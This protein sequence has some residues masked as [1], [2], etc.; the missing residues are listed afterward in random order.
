MTDI[1]D[2]FQKELGPGGLEARGYTRAVDA[3]DT[4]DILTI[5]GVG[6]PYG[7]VARIEGWFEEWDELVAPGAWRSAISR[8]DVDIV[9]SYNHNLDFLI[10]RT[11]DTLTLTDPDEEGLLYQAIVNPDDP[12]AVGIHARVARRD[13]TGSS[14]WFRVEKDMWEEPSEDNDLEVPLRTILRADLYEVGPVVFPAFPTTTAEASAA[15][16]R[17][18]GYKRSALAAMDGSLTAAGVTRRASQ[19]AY[20]F[21]FL[22]DPEPEIRALFLQDPDLR[23]KVC[24]LDTAATAASLAQPHVSIA[25]SEVLFA[26]AAGK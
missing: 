19:A 14:V 5:S 11:P 15:G 2:R 10:A 25:N 23:D 8:P 12:N 17:H 22:A 3:G 21:R 13:V 4:D 18:L 6:S 26:I 9:S 1:R 24:A 20:A 16:F 7:Q